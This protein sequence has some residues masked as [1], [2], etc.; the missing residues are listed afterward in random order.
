MG[1]IHPY[2]QVCT[3]NLLHILLRNPY[4]PCFGFESCRFM[5]YI[6]VYK[7]LVKYR[8][9]SLLH[10]THLIFSDRNAQKS[11]KKKKTSTPQPILQVGNYS[12]NQ[13]KTLQI[14]NQNFR[15]LIKI[16]AFPSS[17][18]APLWRPQ[19]TK[20]TQPQSHVA[21][22][23]IGV[24]TATPSQQ[25][26]D[27]AWPRPGEEQGLPRAGVYVWVRW[28]QWR[29]RQKMTTPS[30]QPYSHLHLLTIVRGTNMPRT[31]LAGASRER[32]I[33]GRCC[34]R[35][36]KGGICGMLGFVVLRALRSRLPLRGGRLVL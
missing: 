23:S 27:G 5:L 13:K 8:H 4:W 11:K 12:N 10:L 29:P 26:D 7:D 18:P 1:R 36:T 2:L 33:V 17:P 35:R 15:T 14:Q 28:M 16:R 21:H 25:R 30:M 9:G 31:V 3:Y 22:P 24:I 6:V 34:C 32:S 19:F 20:W